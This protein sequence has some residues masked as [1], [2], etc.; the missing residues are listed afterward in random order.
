[1]QRFYYKI[2]VCGIFII[3]GCNTPKAF[4][5]QI[6]FD[7][8]ALIAQAETY[9]QQEPITIT[10]FPAER[11]VGGLHDYYSEGSYWWQNPDDP[12]GPYIRRDGY[13][14]PANF[15]KHSNA[16]RNLNKWVT[17]LVAAYEVTGDEKYARQALKHL[18]AWFVNADTK[19]NP[20]LLY[21]QAI[22]G[23]VT[24]RGIGIIDTV[25]LIEVALSIIELENSGFLKGEALVNIKEWFNAYAT[26]LTTHPYGIDERDNGN[27]HSTWWAAQVAVYAKVADRPDLL[28]LAQ[29][30][31]KKMLP[32]QM[33]ADGR[34]PEELARTKPYGYTVYNLDAWTTL[35]R[36]A[37]T[38]KEN[39]WEYK[40]PVGSLRKAID[41]F[42]P[43]VKDKSKWTLP[44]DVDGFENQPH[45]SNFLL[46]AAMGY[47]DESYYNL[48]K[49]LGK[50]EESQSWQLMLY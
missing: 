8:Q 9:L 29:A 19:M 37:S 4:I 12:D 47:Q 39:L 27:N 24:G 44:P 26:W 10:S 41:F 33:T 21:G 3:T 28:A 6:D 48:W 7:N 16:M 15:T 25:K 45:Q 34:F 43:F 14:N 42:V 1:M 36:L 46:F 11:S 50:E 38:K 49:S 20:S 22:K 40:S 23:I 17:T 18:N 2:V 5:K 31:F 35:A 13:R 30:Q 32:Q